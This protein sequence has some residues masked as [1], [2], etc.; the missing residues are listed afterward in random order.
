[1]DEFGLRINHSNDPNMRVIPFFHHF[2]HAAYSLLFPLQ[3][4]KAE[5]NFELD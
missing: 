2:E 1:M 4:V 3:D 5:G